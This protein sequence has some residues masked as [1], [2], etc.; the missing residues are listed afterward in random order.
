[1]LMHDELYSNYP[2]LK[3]IK[4]KKID[5]NEKYNQIELVDYKPAASLVKTIEELK[6]KIARIKEGRANDSILG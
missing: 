5:N 3:K 6:N 4:V 1:M 2:F